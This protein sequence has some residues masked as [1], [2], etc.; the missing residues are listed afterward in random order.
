MQRSIVVATDV[1]V[2]ASGMS[3][4]LGAA[5]IHLLAADAVAAVVPLAVVAIVMAD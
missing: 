5:S 3:G 4:M 1:A 2:E